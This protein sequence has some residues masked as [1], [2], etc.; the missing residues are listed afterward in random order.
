MGCDTKGFITTDKKDIWETEKIIR[1]FL[2]TRPRN[3]A[4]KW[5]KNPNAEQTADFRLTG[6]GRYFT[7]SFEDGDDKR[8]LNVFF[9]CDSNYEDVYQGQKIVFNLGC[10]GKS[11]ELMK[12]ILEGMKHLGRAF[13]IYNDCADEDWQ[14]LV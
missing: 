8:Q 4:P 9:D 14:E 12:G 10:W 5:I 3:N 7:A 6:I 13:Y 11:D 2:K 1:D